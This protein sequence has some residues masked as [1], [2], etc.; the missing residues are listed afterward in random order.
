VPS[1]YDQRRLDLLA[2]GFS[3]VVNGFTAAGRE[4][5]YPSADWDF[6]FGHPC[7]MENAMRKF[8]NASRPS[9]K[10]IITLIGLAI[11]FVTPSHVVAQYITTDQ[12]RQQAQQNLAQHRAQ[13]QQQQQQPV[14]GSTNTV[15]GSTNTYGREWQEQQLQGNNPKV[16]RPW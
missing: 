16:V 15:Q 11:A 13:Q 6:R 9:A 7:T 14:Q 3:P 4:G 1:A 5:R 12:Q 8:F 2:E 10:I